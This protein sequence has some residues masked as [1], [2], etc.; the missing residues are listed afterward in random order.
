MNQSPIGPEILRK[1]DAFSLHTRRAVLGFR[2]GTHR[3]IRRGHGV[4]FAEYRQYEL[5]D[6]PRYI[7]WNLYGRSDK[8]YIKRY[9]EEENVSVFIVIDGSGSL[10]HPDLSIKWQ[11]AKTLATYAGYIALASQDP[12]TI[13]VLGHASS[14]AFAGGRAFSRIPALLTSLESRF[15]YEPK[16]I[17]LIKEAR[18]LASRMNFPGV[19]IFL[20]DFLYPVLEVSEVL[21]AFRARNMEVHAVQV[22]SES[23][24]TP[25]NS[26]DGITLADSETGE[27]APLLL[28][29]GSLLTY[30]KRMVSHVASVR[31][32]CLSHQVQ[33][34]S[35]I[36]KEP[37]S[38]GCI[39]ALQEMSL[40]I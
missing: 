20:S 17:D 18:R 21:A 27:S 2:Q 35:H 1:L 38:E 34:S 6:N 30:Q 29:A 25:G 8:L 26:P 16:D 4:E 19:C 3:S 40:F 24:V 13:S 39:S 23:D 36:A 10:T 7:D 12:V 33:F 31:S 15:T 37:L 5:G 32:H 14:P 28:D 9:L 11:F 22:L